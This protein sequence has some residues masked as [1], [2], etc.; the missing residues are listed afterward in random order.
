M[1]R[2]H[3]KHM[4]RTNKPNENAATDPVCGMQ[5]ERRDLGGQTYWICSDGCQTKFDAGP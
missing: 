1:D 4:H 5:G 3:S 2:G